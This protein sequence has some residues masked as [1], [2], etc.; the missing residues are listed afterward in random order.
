MHVYFVRHGET[1]L[2]THRV[3]QSP[4]TPL[5]ARGADQARSVAEF[6]SPTNPT[7]LVTST[8]D[9]ALQTARIISSS[10]GIPLTRNYL[11]REVDWPSILTGRRIYSFGALWYIFLS[12]V[13]R[14]R[15]MWRYLDAENFNDIY[16]RIQKTFAY[17]E[18]IT[19][20]HNAIVIVSH[21]EYIRLMITYMCHGEKLTFSEIFST[22]G[23]TQTLGN[24]EVIHVEYIGP[25][26]KGTC[27]WLLHE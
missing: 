14:N 3:H 10:V 23:R 6:L 7:L 5:N 20:E 1:D 21:S 24:C 9:R 15:P 13:F 8:Y 16:T 25:T 12:L 11:F 19:E 2:N 26:P 4:H 22:L 27:P 17:I 18:S